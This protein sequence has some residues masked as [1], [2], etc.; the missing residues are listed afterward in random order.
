[1]LQ[2]WALST[3]VPWDSMAV[4]SWPCFTIL[5]SSWQGTRQAGPPEHVGT[6]SDI[7]H[8]L[9]PKAI[10]DLASKEEERRLHG[11]QDATGLSHVP[12]ATACRLCRACPD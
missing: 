12:P 7:N 9:H 3:A 10:N 8:P 11:K 6:E 1:M 4:N 5:P 2:T